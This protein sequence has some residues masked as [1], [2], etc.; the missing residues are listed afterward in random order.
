MACAVPAEQVREAGIALDIAAATISLCGSNKLSKVLTRVLLT[1]RDHSIATLAAQLATEADAVVANFGIALPSFQA[2]KR[3]NGVAVLNFPIAHHRYIQ[4]VL[5]EEARRVPMFA[6]TMQYEYSTERCDQLDAEV[7]LADVVLVGSTFLRNT[8][9][10]E[11]ITAS[12]IRVTPYGTNTSLFRPRTEPKP[13]PATFRVIFVGQMTQR[14]GLSYLLEAFAGIPSPDMELVL[15]GK[16]VG[17]GRWLSTVG[18]RVT[19]VPHCHKERLAE[20]YR[21][22]DVFVLPTLVEGMPLVL[23]EAMASGLPVIVTPNGTTDIVRDGV[24]GFIVEPRDSPAIRDRILAL[25]G[26]TDKRTTMGRRAATRAAQ[27]TWDS[28]RDRI[29]VQLADVLRHDAESSATAGGSV[30]RQRP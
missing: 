24:E 20:L 27:F 23:L 8:F 16:M 30:A 5:L 28:Y 3:R 25:R 18:D 21:S 7:A 6:E 9:T 1:K 17:S 10:Q 13:S 22:A 4:R 29:A 14:K 11:G 19:F 26:D 12:K 2:I 15:V